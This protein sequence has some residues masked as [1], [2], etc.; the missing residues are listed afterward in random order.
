MQLTG[1]DI[2]Q[3][4]NTGALTISLDRL[5]GISVD[6]ATGIATIGGGQ[7]LGDVALGLFEQGERALSHGT[8]PMVR[9]WRDLP[10]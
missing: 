4:L 1:A 10:R 3:A 9:P 5:N 8:C 6:N 7:R 2:S